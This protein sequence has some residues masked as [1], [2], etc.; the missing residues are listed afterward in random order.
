MGYDSNI[1]AGTSED[2]IY[3]PFLDQEIILSENSKENSDSY[4]GLGYQLIGSKALTQSS[5]LTFFGSGKL[6][7]F[8]NDS[9]FNRFTLRTNVQ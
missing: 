7:N 2:N 3:L 1:N 6:H 9:E 4:L 5:K 8:N